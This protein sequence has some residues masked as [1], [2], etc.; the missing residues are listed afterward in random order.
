MSKEIN[1]VRTFVTSE[2]MLNVNAPGG[3]GYNLLVGGIPM[4]V[5][6]LLAVLLLILVIFF[7]APAASFAQG[8]NDNARSQDFTYKS[9]DALQKA[10]K[11]LAD[12]DVLQLERDGVC[13]TLR[14]YVMARDEK[15]SDSTHLVRETRCLP[16]ARLQFKTATEPVLRTDPAGR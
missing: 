15:D 2:A 16:A 12:R 13:Y 6:G 3:R 4:R 5:T 1:A 9:A 10:L 8:A 14:T 11:G 7:A